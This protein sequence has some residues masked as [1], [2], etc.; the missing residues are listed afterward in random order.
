MGSQS[1]DHRYTAPK[2]T[3]LNTV[4]HD[5]LQAARHE[6][7]HGGYTGSL[8][9]KNSCTLI[10]TVATREQAERVV[11]DLM[12]GWSDTILYREEV[13]QIADDKYGP[14]GVIRYTA[15]AT[16]F[17]YIFFGYASS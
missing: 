5:A 6:Y 11:N 9:E 4:F 17:G 7:G 13:S 16:E 15:S 8:A 3:P 10:C 1:F 12:A 2:T 14:A